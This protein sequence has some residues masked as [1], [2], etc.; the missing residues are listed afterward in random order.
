MTITVIIPTL[1]RKHYVINLL[2]DLNNQSREVIQVIVSD[3]SKDFEEITNNYNFEFIHFKNNNSGPCISRND[4]AKLAIGEI[5]VFLDDDARIENNFIKEITDPLIKGF[6]VACA[7]A[8]CD[9]DGNYKETNI[10]Q[11]LFLETSHWIISFTKNPNHSGSHFCNAAPAGCFAILKT[12][13]DEIGGYD[14]FFDPNGAGE[15]REMAIRLLQN[16]NEIFYNGKAKLFHLAEINGGRRSKS[17]NNTSDSFNKNIAYTLLKHFGKN[18]FNSYCNKQIKRR[19]KSI[20]SFDKPLYNFNQLR[21]F[22][23]SIKEVKNF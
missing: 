13:F 22:L 21:V 23:K 10:K 7:G 19:L 12:V 1:N 11:P 9:A 5:I 18:E 2:D 8:I 3:Q 4:A 6:S 14:V 20:I 17:N 16:R 15:D